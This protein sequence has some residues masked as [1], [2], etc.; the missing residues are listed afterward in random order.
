[1]ASLQT[2]PELNPKSPD[3]IPGLEEDIAE[4][5]QSLD[6]DEA[7]GTYR[8][9]HSIKAIGDRL[10]SVARKARQKGSLDAQTIVKKKSEGAVRTS[11]TV[12]EDTGADKIAPGDSIAA[13]ISK[14]FR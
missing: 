5:Y 14:M 1:V 6:F 8:G 4:Q 2:E 7:T 12:T 9:T 13:G 10:I 3:F 11:P